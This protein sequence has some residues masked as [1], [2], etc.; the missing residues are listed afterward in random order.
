VERRQGE[1]DRG[2]KT[3]LTRNP[4]TRSKILKCLLF[5]KGGSKTFPQLLTG[6]TGDKKKIKL[7]KK[8]CK[9]K[10]RKN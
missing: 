4:I 5:E 7:E 6:L 3:D 2:K 1:N 10:K 8:E 9:G